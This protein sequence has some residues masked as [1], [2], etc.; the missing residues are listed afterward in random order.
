MNVLLECSP[1]G[2]S[3][4]R[5]ARIGDLFPLDPTGHRLEAS[6][7]PPS[8]VRPWGLRHV[9]RLVPR[10]GGHSGGTKETTGDL[11]GN[12]P[13]GEETNSD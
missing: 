6:D 12:R 7:E 10:A 8:A 9:R 2:E 3:R 11:D 4:G 5:I 13:S 1:D